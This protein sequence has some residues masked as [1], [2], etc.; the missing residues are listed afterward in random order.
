[1]SAHDL[2]SIERKQRELLEHVDV[3]K[4]S[5]IWQHYKGDL[6][7]VEGLVM[8]EG[9]EEIDVCYLNVKRPLPLPWSRPLTEWNDLVDINGKQVRRF[10]LVDSETPPQ[11]W[12]SY[13]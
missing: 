5:S 4:Q 7:R 10:V 1:M 11:F 12:N 9:T 6:Y 2:E 8:R 13:R 3:P